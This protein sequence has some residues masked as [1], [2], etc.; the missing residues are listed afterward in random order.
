MKD[1]SGP[2]SEFYLPQMIAYLKANKIYESEEF[3]HLNEGTQQQLLDQTVPNY[4]L[5]SVCQMLHLL[6]SFNL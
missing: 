4:E 6:K 3:R 5:F 2:L 1:Q